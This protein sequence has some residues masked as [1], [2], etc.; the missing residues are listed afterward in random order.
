[1]KKWLFI[2][3]LGGLACLCTYY[4]PSPIQKYAGLKDNKGNPFSFTINEHIIVDS[5]VCEDDS[6]FVVPQDSVLRL[7]DEAMK[8]FFLKEEY[9][10][11]LANQVQTQL[12]NE[13]NASQQIQV[14]QQQSTDYEQK[15]QEKIER[16]IALEDSVVYNFQY[17]D[18]TIYK[19]KYIY[20]PDTVIVEVL[21]TVKVRKI[22][23]KK[24]K[25]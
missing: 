14:L 5:L 1:M 23:K 22:K 7:V 25:K 19:P 4:I 17:R 11:D 8:Q 15:L 3:F 24:G 18:T 6:T 10:K 2:L 13:R 21:D 20:V 9:S 12:N 16:S